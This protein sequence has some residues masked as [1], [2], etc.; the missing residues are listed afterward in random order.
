MKIA[1]YENE[2]YAVRGKSMVGLKSFS[3][4]NL[5]D[6]KKIERIED[7]FDEHLDNARG[8][9]E[10]LDPPLKPGILACLGR[11]YA[12]HAKETGHNVPKEPVFFSKAVSSITGHGHDIIY[13]KIVTQLD[14]E[15]E[16]AVIIGKRGKYISKE[17]AWDYIAGYTIM[18]DVS[19]R[20]HQF[21]YE[22]Q[23]FVGKS[24]DT[25]APIGP[26]IIDRFELGDPHNLNLKTQVNG[27]IRQNSNTSNMIFKIDFLI[28]FISNVLTLE[29]GD[30]ILTGTP[31]GVALGTK[32]QRFL[33]VGDRIEME[34]EKIG[35]LENSVIKE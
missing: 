20:D 5:L 16:L 29:P 26:W 22:N 28:N 13:P 11:N 24:F 33:K 30:V 2:Y 10:R 27:E 8:I 1:K 14:Y 3:I 9:P 4:E 18:N 21:R 23:W 17:D 25:F 12:E 31:S 19:A 7:Y 15:V 34:I 32:D 6:T 35:K